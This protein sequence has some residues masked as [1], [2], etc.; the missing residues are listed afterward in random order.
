VNRLLSAAAVAALTFVPLSVSAEGPTG[1]SGLFFDANTKAPIMGVRVVV[2]R[3]EQPPQEKRELVTDKEGFFSDLGLRPGGYLVIAE[4]RNQIIACNVNDVREGIV[5][6]VRFY[7]GDSI[8]GTKCI[9]PTVHAN[10][11]D[12][13]ETASVYRVR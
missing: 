2:A 9:G 10:T 1:V 4:V 7:V 12:P 11:L 13:D 8:G 5:R 6:R 3:D